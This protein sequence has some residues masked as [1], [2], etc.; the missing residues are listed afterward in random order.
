[1]IKRIKQ[2]AKSRTMI[3]MVVM[4]GLE[5]TAAAM[6]YFEPILTEQQFGIVSAVLAI[7]TA[8]VGMYM[9]QI[10]TVAIQDK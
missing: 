1:M 6:T 2:Q 9:R 3:A 10:T 4:S 7:A 5:A 8:M